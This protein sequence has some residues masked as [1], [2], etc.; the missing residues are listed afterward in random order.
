MLPAEGN[1]QR[2]FILL[3]QTGVIARRAGSCAM[4]DHEPRQIREE[5]AV[6]D[7][8]HVPQGGLV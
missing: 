6:S 8:F 5:A 2:C 4:E 1:S 7:P 3:G